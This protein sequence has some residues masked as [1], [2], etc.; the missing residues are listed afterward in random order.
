[1]ASATSFTQRHDHLHRSTAAKLNLSPCDSAVLF[2][3]CAAAAVVRV[4]A[5]RQVAVVLFAAVYAVFNGGDR[6]ALL[7]RAARGPRGPEQEK[8]KH[9][10]GNNGHSSRRSRLHGSTVVSHDQKAIKIAWF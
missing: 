2:A 7:P 10:V 5:A 9:S 6:H 4:S 8:E 1:M 3:V